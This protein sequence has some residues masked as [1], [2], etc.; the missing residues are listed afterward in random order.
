MNKEIEEAITYLRRV[1]KT[2]KETAY[3]LVYQDI[4]IQCL[5][6]VLNYIEELEKENADAKE[7]ADEVWRKQEELRNKIEELEERKDTKKELI[8]KIIGST[9]LVSKDGEKFEFRRIK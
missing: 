1:I 2:S 6:I 5:E 9:Q 4:D 7:Y 8:D 3:N